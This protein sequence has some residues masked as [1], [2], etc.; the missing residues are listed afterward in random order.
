MTGNR[1]VLSRLRKERTEENRAAEEARMSGRVNKRKSGGW[2]KSADFELESAFINLTGREKEGRE[3]ARCKQERE[4]GKEL[5][6]SWGNL[7]RSK[8]VQQKKVICKCSK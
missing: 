4:R 3:T 2:A 1:K 7:F 6:L 5:L 8:S